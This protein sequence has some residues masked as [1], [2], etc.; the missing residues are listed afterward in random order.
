MK[1]KHL[2]LLPF[3]ISALQINAQS[4]QLHYDARHTLDS[5]RNTKNFPTL[6]FEYFKTLDTGTTF[7]KPGSFLLKLQAD[8]MGEQSNIGKYYMQISQEVRFWK[9]KVFV[10]L[11]FSGGLGITTP[12]EY[13]YYI[14]NTYS[15]GV[16][17]PFKWGSAYLSSVL[18]FR[19][20]PYK[21]PS[22]DPFYT[23]YYYKALWN[24]KAELAGDFSVWTENRDHGDEL[25]AH[26]KGKQF[27]FF[28]EPQFWLNVNKTLALGTKINMFYHVLTNDND[29]QVYPTAAIRIKL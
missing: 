28:A 17:Y 27:F 29:F 2:A 9:P 24:Y 20:I 8:L 3:F 1:L 12:R 26:L 13:S 19:Y 15:V 23:L 7:I 16:S 6:Y 11:Q 4:L 21:K 14:I 10:N 25:T 5:R 22:K 18:N